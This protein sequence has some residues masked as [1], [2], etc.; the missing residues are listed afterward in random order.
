[1]DQEIPLPGQVA[2]EYKAKGK[3]PNLVHAPFFPLKRESPSMPE[4]I[5]LVFA[6]KDQ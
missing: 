2:T 4:S 3:P 6:F 1:M 5:L